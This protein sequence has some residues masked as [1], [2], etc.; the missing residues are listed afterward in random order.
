MSIFFYETFPSEKTL[1]SHIVPETNISQTTWNSPCLLAH[2][3]HLFL[4]TSPWNWRCDHHGKM[5]GRPS[6]S[7]PRNFLSGT[8]HQDF[9]LEVLTHQVYLT[10]TPPIRDTSSCQQPFLDVVLFVQRLPQKGTQNKCSHSP[11]GVVGASGTPT[12]LYLFQA[13]PE[14]SQFSDDDG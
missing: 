4:D 8:S 13:V 12:M 10:C 2:S 1:I 5:V 9:Q 11:L 3:N 14:A 7:S 6:D